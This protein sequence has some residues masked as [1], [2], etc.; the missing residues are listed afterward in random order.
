MTP[1]IYKICIYKIV[2]KFLF[3]NFNLLTCNFFP[4]VHCYAM[5]ILTTYA[6]IKQ[7]I[8]EIPIYICLCITVLR[9]K[10]WHKLS[11]I[12]LLYFVLNK[13]SKKQINNRNRTIEHRVVCTHKIHVVTWT[14]V[15]CIRENDYANWKSVIIRFL[16][17]YGRDGRHCIY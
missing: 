16:F 17:L 5:E 13:T 1:I 9:T 15:F 2:K 12:L 4:F 7:I 8:I 14:Y 10:W 3:N 6:N 11:D